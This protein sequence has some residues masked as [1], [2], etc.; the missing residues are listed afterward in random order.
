MPHKHKV[1]IAG[2]HEL[3]FD[4]KTDNLTNSKSYRNRSGTIDDSPVCGNAAVDIQM[5][6]DEDSKTNDNSKPA[7]LSNEIRKE[8]TN[9]TYLE[10]SSVDICGVKVYGRFLYI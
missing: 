6:E 7:T 5:V 9:C 3:G 2:N 4:P 1:V 10:D 8:L